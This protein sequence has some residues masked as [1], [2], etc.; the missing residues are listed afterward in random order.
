MLKQ[1]DLILRT[2]QRQ[3][4]TYREKLGKYN[5]NQLTAMTTAI[6]LDGKMSKEGAAGI[7]K[8]VFNKDTNEKIRN[9]ILRKYQIKEKNRK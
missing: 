8:I 2:S 9:T 4:P 3:A 6:T 1:P 5:N 7:Q